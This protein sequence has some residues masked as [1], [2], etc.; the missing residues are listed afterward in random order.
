MTDAA[1]RRAVETIR[2]LRKEL[3]EKKT[4]RSNAQ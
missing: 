2:E 3:E 1:N 4:R